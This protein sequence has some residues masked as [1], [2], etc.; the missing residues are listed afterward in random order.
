MRFGARTVLTILITLG[1]VVV[2]LTTINVDQ[3]TGALRQSDWRW[4]VV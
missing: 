2:V 4:S 3:I 1:A